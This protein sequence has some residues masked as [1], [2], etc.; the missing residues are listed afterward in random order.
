MPAFP[1]YYV[2]KGSISYSPD[3][4]GGPMNYLFAA[5][6]VVWLGFFLYLWSLSRRQRRLFRKLEALKGR[7]GDV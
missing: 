4:E 1:S 7:E 6:S 5:Y 3:G 2:G